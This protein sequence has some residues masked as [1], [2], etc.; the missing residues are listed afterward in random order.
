MTFVPG[1]NRVAVAVGGLDAALGTALTGD[2]LVLAPGT[3]TASVAIPTGVTVRGQPGQRAN[4]IV[5]CALW[6]M[7]PWA[8]VRDVTLVNSGGDAVLAASGGAGTRWVEGISLASS[9]LLFEA[10][11]AWT[12]RN[13]TFD[14]S[15]CYT[16]GTDPLIVSSCLFTGTISD[17]VSNASSGGD[18][19]VYNCTFS[20]NV[21]SAPA[22]Q[23]G[24]ASAA[25]SLYNNVFNTSGGA[26][27][28]IGGV[29]GTDTIYGN[30]SNYN[31]GSSG[32]GTV[33][34][35]LKLDPVTYYPLQDSPVRIGNAGETGDGRLDVNYLPFGSSRSAGAFQWHDDASALYRPR[36]VDPLSGFDLTYDLE[37]LDIAPGRVNFTSHLELAAYVRAYVNDL[38]HP[39][40]GYFYTDRLGNYRLVTNGDLFDLTITGQSATVFG[41]QTYTAEEDT[42]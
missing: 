13:C 10:E 26:V 39:S 30:Y 12:V 35:D 14:S 31:L 18:V 34:S 23:G 29:G 27:A 9:Y 21:G 36:Y 15:F 37:N 2:V 25:N 4:T 16:V 3:H 17:A 20:G 42:D 24:G 7:A 28:L 11:Q 22:I 38:I 40:F 1:T 41:A 33:V 19:T 8:T 6:G 5:S 32:Y